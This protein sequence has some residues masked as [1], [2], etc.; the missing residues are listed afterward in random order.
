MHISISNAPPM[1]PACRGEINL[2]DAWIKALGLR[3][4]AGCQAL[5]LLPPTAD[6]NPAPAPPKTTQARPTSTKIVG[7]YIKLLFWP[8]AKPDWRST[9]VDPTFLRQL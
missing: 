2:V 5:G 6:A 9:T 3:P 8:N 1:L 4:N 7:D